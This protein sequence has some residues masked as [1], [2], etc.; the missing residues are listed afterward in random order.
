MCRSHK[1]DTKI[2]L[3]FSFLFL[4]IFSPIIYGEDFVEFDYEADIY[5]SNISAFIDLDTANEVAD[6]SLVNE[7]D[8]YSDLL[9]QT[10]DP[11]I[12]LIE[13]A[14]HPM[15]LWGLHIRNKHL[16][17]YDRYNA[18]SSN[19]IKSVTAGFD[20]PYSLSF[21][22]GRMAVFKNKN[23][24]NIGKNRA[25]IGYL[26][27]LGDNSINDNLLY[28][29]RWINLEF[30]LKGTREKEKQDLDWSFRVG[31]KINENE[32]FENTMYIGAR[33]SSIDFDQS[34]YSLFY[35]SAFESMIE[36]SAKTLD[37]TKIELMIEK[38]FP[39]SGESKAVFGLGIGYLLNSNQKY[40]GD[41]E[42]DGIDNHQFLFRP[43]FKF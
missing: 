4:F 6:Y 18:K 31:Y 39:V 8:I 24:K 3:K 10:F 29:N 30:K 26:V 1:S 38:K 20:E 42:R 41:V 7:V 43:N 2:V 15:P 27:T 21:F 28:S 19:L 37:L 34:V 17:Q 14:V 5:Y 40:S 22:F 11:N 32:D 33:R 16:E 23:S 25:Y 13:F 35:N 9:L 12:F 36:F